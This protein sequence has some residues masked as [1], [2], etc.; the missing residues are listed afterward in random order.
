M[1]RDG[2]DRTRASRGVRFPRDKICEYLDKRTDG[3]KRKDEN[4]KPCRRRREVK[5]RHEESEPESRAPWAIDK[6][7]EG[8]P[9]GA[10]IVSAEPIADEIRNRIIDEEPR[11]TKNGESHEEE[12][13]GGHPD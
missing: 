11:E 3:A 8:S 10:R 5:E 12:V 1:G 9:E 6:R 2:D 4:D 13:K 7:A